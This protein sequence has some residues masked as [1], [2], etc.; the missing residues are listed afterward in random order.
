MRT[1]DYLLLKHS[2]DK[3]TIQF[4]VKKKN[5]FLNDQKKKIRPE[6]IILFILFFVA[7]CLF[8]FRL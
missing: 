5:L 8:W 7:T 3:K 4:F 2:F 6:E 1:I